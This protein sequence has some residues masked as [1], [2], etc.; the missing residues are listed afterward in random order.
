MVGAC[1][2][3][4]MHTSINKRMEHGCSKWSGAGVQFY[5]WSMGTNQLED[6]Y[7]RRELVNFIQGARTIF[8][9]VFVSQWAIHTRQ[10]EHVYSYSG[11]CVQFLWSICMFTWRSTSS[12]YR[13]VQEHLLW[14][15]FV[16][17][18]HAYN[19][20]GAYIQLQWSTC[21]HIVGSCFTVGRVVALT[22][23]IPTGNSQFWTRNGSKQ[24]RRCPLQFS[25]YF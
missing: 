9:Q 20:N 1:V 23:L 21:I 15:S 18:Q 3:W 16:R 24:L 13:T 11:A 7:S 12:T 6:V 22:L 2:Q 10:M 25:F 19:F 4:R 8:H 14:Y 17:L 5:K